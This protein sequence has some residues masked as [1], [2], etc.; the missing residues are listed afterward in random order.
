MTDKLCVDAANK[1]G[2]AG[3][4]STIYIEYTNP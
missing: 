4:Y 3:V 2:R 1:I